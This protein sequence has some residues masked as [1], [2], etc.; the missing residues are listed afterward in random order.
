MCHTFK[1]SQLK[2]EGT[3]YVYVVCIFY[4]ISILNNFF[5]LYRNLF[6][7]SEMVCSVYDC[8]S[9][10]YSF[11]GSSEDNLSVFVVLFIYV[12]GVTVLLITYFKDHK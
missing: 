12:Y 9:G 10:T 8:L 7:H 6:N 3:H 11:S 5:F 2:H 4:K 1:N